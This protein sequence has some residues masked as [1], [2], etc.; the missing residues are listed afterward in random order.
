MSSKYNKRDPSFLSTLGICFGILLLIYF[1][2]LS[3]DN[4]IYQQMAREI[5]QY[6]RLPYVATW[7]QNFPGIIYMHYLAIRLFGLADTSVRIIDILLQ[8]GF[9]AV[10]YKLCRIWLNDHTSA[11][12][13][14]LYASFFVAGGQSVYFERDGYA[15]MCCITSFYLLVRE[16]HN[17]LYRI[18]NFLLAS[19]LTGYALI[20][21]PTAL[22]YA[23]PIAVFI[24]FHFL[25]EDSVSKRLFRLVAFAIIVLLPI[26]L[27]LQF[28]SGLPGGL[29]ALYLATIRYN[30]DIYAGGRSG[31]REIALNLLRTGFLFP[32]AAYGAWL[33]YREKARIF[34]N[35][36]FPKLS[37]W[38]YNIAIVITLSVVVIQGKFWQYQWMP[39]CIV[40]IPLAAIAIESIIQHAH[41]PV[42]RHY[43]L[44]GCIVLCSFIQMNPK[45]QAS[46][47]F[48]IT[49]RQPLFGDTYDF[50]T[51]RPDFGVKAEHATLH[52]LDSIGVKNREVEICSIEPHLRLHFQHEALGAYGLLYPISQRTIGS[53]H[54]F[55][56]T[57]YQREWQRA[58]FDTLRL[59]QPRF[60]VVSL[61]SDYSGVDTILHLIPGFDSFF[62]S[63]YYQDTEFGSYKIYRH[64]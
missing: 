15:A 39:F 32:F 20:L 58:Y 14:I 60:I 63:Q 12:T 44:I 22:L 17:S 6:H 1:E 40:V 4:A 16:Y 23:V 19:L 25:K 49:H 48:D 35:P 54:N 61:A 27:V 55:P 30:L 64:R 46:I 5:Y 18:G 37:H 10:L 34:L 62:S 9:C 11:F 28:Y 21:K 38:Y 31:M 57:S 7:D 13:T 47:L 56:L 43:A 3:Y 2:P 51:L 8:L 36:S 52:Y 26:A 33:L 24:L 53:T 59:N 42:A 41:R 45:S 50:A 29:K